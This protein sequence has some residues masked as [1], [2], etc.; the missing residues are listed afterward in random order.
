MFEPARPEDLPQLR[1]HIQRLRLDGENLAPE[2]FLVVRREGRVVAFGRIKPYR[3]CHELGS[4]G[5]LE[6]ER[7][8]G[9]GE[10][11]VR[12]L[13]RRFP[14]R[15]VWITTDL[16]GYFERFGFVRVEEG[17]PAEL[18]EKLS[19]ICGSLRQNVVAMRLVKSD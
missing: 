5:V 15:D 19:R 17:V 6:S 9:L 4:V 18:S 12:E 16:Q 8:Q 10:A 1:E 7:G 11:M 14:S 3:A 13:I 2:Q